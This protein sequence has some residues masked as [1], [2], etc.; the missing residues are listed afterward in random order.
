MRLAECLNQSDSVSLRRIAEHHGMDCPLYSKN[1][2]LQEI[3]SRLCDP[4]Y[5]NERYAAGASPL[6]M[7]ALQEIALDGRDRYANEE[8]IA[9]LARAVQTVPTK[10]RAISRETGHATE[11]GSVLRRRGGA[12]RRKE[13]TDGK[14]AE[15]GGS[16]EGPQ[17]PDALAQELLHILVREGVVYPTGSD[18]RT[19]YVCPTDFW[20]RLHELA[21]RKMKATVQS[22]A[23]TP[24]VYRQDG[25]AIARDAAAFLLF[26]MRHDV[27]LT[28]EGVIFR[29][30]Q[31]QL[32][33][34]FEVAE[35]VLPQSI[36]W[37]FGFG[38]RFHDYPDRL[39]LIYDHLCA[40]GC[41]VETVDG[42]L[43]VDQETSDAYLQL[44]EENRAQQ[45]FRFWLRT[46]RHAI[47][48]LRTIVAR[49]AELTR[50]AWV[51]ADSLAA[52][53][54][55]Q[56]EPYYYE[57]N[58]QILVARILGMLVHL[59]VLARGAAEDGAVAYRLSPDGAMWCLGKGGD[60]A[61]SEPAQEPALSA[62]AVVQPTF[63]VLL[64]AE[65]EAAIGRDLQTMADLVQSDRMR[66]Y[67]LTRASVYRALS[68]GWEERQILAFLRDICVNP[69][70]GNVEQTIAQWCSVYGKV[71]MGSFLLLTLRD[72]QTAEEV[73][74]YAPVADRLVREVTPT[75][76]AFAPDDAPHLQ[77]FL[78]KMGY[79]V[80]VDRAVASERR[81][82]PGTP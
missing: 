7:A 67:R 48:N 5:L 33:Q 1:A 80:R 18:S 62:A 14:T 51:Y 47:P 49:T 59:G 39:A 70:P 13:R 40:S 25:H 68:Q 57:T 4:E 6:L 69:V 45:L 26:T 23:R 9:L 32:L 43:R 75:V 44:P 50:H 37:R 11:S 41:V 64:P 58:E 52:L 28:Q 73:L 54:L 56:I 30:Q 38:R 24:V 10:D 74:Q 16:E 61:L 55:D 65:A 19:V 53:W 81:T 78:E 63:E 60:E 12:R 42:W 17:R 66:V 76:F 77:S 20:R 3:L 72:R 8:L 22:C 71:T 82:V 27:R 15:T 35:E 21:S 79:L 31:I 2:L 36:G 34:L 46:Y 29:R